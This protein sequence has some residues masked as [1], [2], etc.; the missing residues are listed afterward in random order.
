M[1]SIYLLT[2]QQS[3]N[4]INDNFNAWTDKFTSNSF[5]A[6]LITLGVFVVLCVIINNIANK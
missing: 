3:L 6:G 4:K 2:F 5:V 1:K